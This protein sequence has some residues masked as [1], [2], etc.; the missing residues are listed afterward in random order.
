MTPEQRGQV[1]DQ[2]TQQASAYAS[3]AIVRNEEVLQ[4]ILEMA[5]P[6]PSDHVLDVACGTGILTCALAAHTAHVTGVDLTPA[7]LVQAQKEQVQQGLSNLAWHKADVA[8]LPYPNA[9]F[10]LVVSRFAFHHFP[11]PL[12]VLREM[13]RVCRPGGRIVIADVT[14]AANKAEA[15]NAIEK[16]RDPSHTQ[17]LSPEEWAALLAQADLPAPTRSQLRLAGDLDALLARSFPKEGDEQKIRILYEQALHDDFFDVFPS[18][19]DGKISYR[20][21]I[22]IFVVEAPHARD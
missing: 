7:M 9:A 11:E 13:R 12:A 1:L 8:A 17:A 10:S 6:Q 5:Q 20:L 4:R 19:A 16:L 18:Q 21:P 2:F 15:F 14:P 22:S 3:S